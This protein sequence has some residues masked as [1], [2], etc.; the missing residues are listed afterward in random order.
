MFSNI[1]GMEVLFVM[2]VALIVLGP[3]KL[4]DAARHA[5]KW[6]TEIRRISAGFQ[7]EFR[8]AIQEP[9]IEADARAR[10]A[11]EST[12][13]A[14]ADPFVNPDL[15]AATGTDATTPSDETDSPAD[16]E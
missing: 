14:V 13:K 11:I 5:G 12:K 9:I 6:V 7:R 4:P 3:S 2:V 15:G 10:G 16:D 1:G 8:E